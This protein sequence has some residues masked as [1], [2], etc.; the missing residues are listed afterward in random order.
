M[1][2]AAGKLQSLPGLCQPIFCVPP[3]RALANKVACTYARVVT[4]LSLYLSVIRLRDF[5][6]Q[7]VK[8]VVLLVQAVALPLT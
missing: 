7:G 1:Q 6:F 2:A 3:H 4:A 5:T 8:S